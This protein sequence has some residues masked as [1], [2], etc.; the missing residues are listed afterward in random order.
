MVS[1]NVT[2]PDMMRLLLYVKV[3]IEKRHITGWNETI[4]ICVLFKTKT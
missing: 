2:E 3:W 1:S 4:V